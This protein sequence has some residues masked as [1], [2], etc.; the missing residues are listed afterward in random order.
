MIFRK[1][2]PGRRHLREELRHL[3]GERCHLTCTRESTPG[4]DERPIDRALLDELV[5][6]LEQHFY[7][8]GPPGF[9]DDVTGHLRDMGVDADRIVIEE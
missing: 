2:H 7:V 9:V 5:D 1:R 8:C 4:Y 6:D 3:F